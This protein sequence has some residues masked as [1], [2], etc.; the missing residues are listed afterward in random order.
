MKYR[1]CVNFLLAIQEDCWRIASTSGTDIG[2]IL[3]KQH[4]GVS[5]WGWVVFGY[6]AVPYG[7]ISKSGEF[8]LF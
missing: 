1:L 5:F 4:Q 2:A 8:L 6:P 7:W 3:I